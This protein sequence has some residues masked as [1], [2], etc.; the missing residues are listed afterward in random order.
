MYRQ[1]VGGSTPTRCMIPIVFERVACSILI[2]SGQFISGSGDFSHSCPH[3]P[4]HSSFPQAASFEQTT[5]PMYRTTVL[6]HALAST[7]YSPAQTHAVRTRTTNAPMFLRDI[8]CRGLC[9]VDA[10]RYIEGHS[11]KYVVGCS[12]L[13]GAMGQNRFRRSPRQ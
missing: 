3:Y 5:L 8:Y 9:I 4:A 11:L 10:G 13:Q 1:I 6:S 7:G 2:Q 12:E